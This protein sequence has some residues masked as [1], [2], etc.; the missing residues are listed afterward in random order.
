LSNKIKIFIC[1]TEQS[2][3]NI[4]KEIISEVL[5]VNKNVVF[6]GV[7]GSKMSTMLNKVF[8][9]ITDFNTMGIVEILFSLKKYFNMISY[10]VKYIIRINY[11][12][13]ITIDSP[14]FNYPLIKKLRKNKFRNKAIHIVAPTVWAWRESR[15]KKFAKI[16][17]EIFVLFE[18][19]KKYFTKYKL[20]TTFIG[21]PIYY[22][23]KN[24]FNY[25]PNNFTIAFLPG[26]RL[27]EVNKLLPY[28][29]LAYE[30]LIIHFKNSNIFIPTL[31]H[32]EDKINE[33]VKNWK[34]NVIVS[35]DNKEIEK[36]Y[37]YISKALVCSGT[38]SLEIA[39][40]N[41]P[42]LVIYK[43]NLI[44]ELIAKNFVKVKYASIINI[45]EDKY[46]IPEV[47][48]SKLNNK[49][50]INA[51]KKL[52]HNNDANINQIKGVNLSLHKIQNNT[53]PYS[54]AARQIT[55]YIISKA[56]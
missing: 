47:T 2:G 38:A 24:N 7:G 23:N 53:P 50:F 18:F 21:H 35:S 32:L 41:I 43:L 14:D 33:F 4:G 22:I 5:K 46:I 37:N 13:V 28:F 56:N 6:E 3:D 49:T 31:P 42:Q 44:T 17:D 10:L 25:S 36:N 34:L 9:S 29:K 8:Y 52:M 39:K 30:Y 1:A 16:F 15:A 19:E 12:L 20:K 48:N 45:I 54:L 51:F 11:D 27:S 40:R 26:S 55:S